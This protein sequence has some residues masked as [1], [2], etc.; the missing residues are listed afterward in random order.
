MRIG[1]V[2][3]GAAG[4]F[5]AANLN[6]LK[7]Q[8]VVL[9]KN[10]DTLKKLLI[11]GH[12]RCNVTNLKQPE[13]FLENVPHN[14]NF[15]FSAINTFSPNNL[16]EFLNNNKIETIQEDNNRI[17]PKTNK[18]QTIKNCFDALA[19]FNADVKL[20]TEVLS[21]SKQD[22]VFEVK[23]C[24][25]TYF[26][27]ALII[28][29]GGVT[30]PTTGSTGFGYNVAN[31]FNVDTIKPRASLCGIRLKNTPTNLEGT[32]LNCKLSI[33]EG[34]KVVAT[35]LGKFLF[36]SFGV[37]G[38]NVFTLSAKTEKHSIAGNVLS[39][40]LLPNLSAEQIKQ[41]LKTYFKNNATKFVFHALNGLINQKLAKFI[42]AKCDVLENKQCANISN[43][44]LNKIAEALK[45]LRFEIDNFDNLERATI[46]RGGVSVKEINPKTMECKKVENLFFIGEVLDVDGLSGGYNLQIAFS[47][48]VA[49][50][51]Y[52]NGLGGN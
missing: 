6:A 2:G 28:A 24:N 41:T 39:F 7:H 13:Q 51:N 42:L 15:L 50:A 23:T 20:E 11:T 18:A 1:I 26:F 27:D 30:Y 44:E 40:D 49:C 25:G 17:F 12:G 47:T 34:N 10:A 5:C 8:V 9:E 31:S 45:A 43:D 14:K 35:N 33:L 3:G 32:P 16:V 29:T 19:S 48:A 37:S 46:T 52:L 22:G 38:P 36:T 21:V 4:M